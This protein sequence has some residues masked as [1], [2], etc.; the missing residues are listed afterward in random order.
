MTTATAP[1][2]RPG[3]GAGGVREWA[4]RRRATH[5]A[6]RAAVLLVGSVLVA[7]GAVMLVLPGPGW[8]VILLGLVVLA[9]EFAWAQRR[10]EPLRRFAERGV[11]VI[12][13]RPGG[14]AILKG[15]VVAGCLS[16]V[17]GAAIAVST[18]T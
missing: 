12:R 9:S 2:G 10:L 11:G 18:L 3:T 16:L 13:E 4:R 7:V 6:L 15:L 1:P 14:P 17:A 8:A 5:L